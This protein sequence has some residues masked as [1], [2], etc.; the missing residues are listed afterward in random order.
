MLTRDKN[1]YI[2]QQLSHQILY[3]IILSMSVWSLSVKS[4]EMN[5][6]EIKF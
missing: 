4:Q 6:T 3:S 2:N 5:K 1:Q